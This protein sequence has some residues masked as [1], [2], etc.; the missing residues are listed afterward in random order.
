MTLAREERPDTSTFSDP[1]VFYRSPEKNHIGLV[2]R[3]TSH[4]RIEILLDDYTS[5]LSAMS[6]SLPAL[7]KPLH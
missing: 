7:S 5:R 6:A 2:T 3:A 1:E 4:A